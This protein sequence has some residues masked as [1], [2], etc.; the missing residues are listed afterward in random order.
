MLSFKNTYTYLSPPSTRASEGQG[1][2]GSAPYKSMI[3]QACKGIVMVCTPSAPSTH[4]PPH[5]SSSAPTL[6]LSIFLC[7]HS[8]IC[9]HNCTTLMIRSSLDQHW[10]HTDLGPMPRSA[11]C[12]LLMYLSD[13]LL[14]AMTGNHL[15]LV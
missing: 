2:R 15:S 1:L 4:L 8:D 11:D 13:P 3:G 6:T 5:P 7:T 14:L 12:I 10:T 9:T